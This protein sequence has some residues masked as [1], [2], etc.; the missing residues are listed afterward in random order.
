DIKE[1][2]DV[3]DLTESAFNATWKQ[4]EIL[5]DQLLEA[6]IKHE[7][8]KS[9][10]KSV[11]KGNSVNTKFDKNNVSNQLLCVTPLNKQVFQKKIVAPKAEE[12]HVLLKTVT[13]QTSPNK[14]N[15]VE[16]NK[17]VIAPGMYKVKTSKKQEINTH[18]AK[19]VLPS[20]GLKAGF[21]VKRPSNRDS[22]FKDS[23]LSNTKNSSEKVEVSV[24]TNKKT[25]VAS[26]NVVSNKK[27]VTDV[28]FKNALKAKNVLCVSCVKNVLI[29]CHDKCLAKY[30]L[31]VH[32][33]V[34]RALFTT[35]RTAKSA[36]VDT[37]PVVLKTR[38]SIKTT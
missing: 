10:L 32:S 19:S 8:L 28:N 21:S 31:N 17:N 9:K 29:P 13:L 24:R 26:K 34:R 14:K 11:E 5:N 7:I 12:K 36:F 2:K 18:K 37:T 38:F 35:P 23:V 15:N 3:Y 16:T 4:N 6:K 1:I 30:K 25:Y 22:S 27:I 33:K 20:I